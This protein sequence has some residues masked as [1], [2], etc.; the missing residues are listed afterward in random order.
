MK[1]IHFVMQ[2]QC[3][4]KTAKVFFENKQIENDFERG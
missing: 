2:I 3:G 4:Q 1:R